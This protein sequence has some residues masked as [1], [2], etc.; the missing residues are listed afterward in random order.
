MGGGVAASKEGSRLNT[1]VC[2]KEGKE[3]FGWGTQWKGA[4]GPEK[5]LS[6][7]EAISYVNE[8]PPSSIVCNRTLETTQVSINRGLQ[9]KLWNSFAMEYHAAIKKNVEDIK[10]A[11]MKR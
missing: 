4:V 6:H 7:A 10:C 2:S 1:W 5:G 11:D 3:S 9:N 8:V